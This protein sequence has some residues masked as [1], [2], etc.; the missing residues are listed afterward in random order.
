MIKKTIEEYILHGGRERTLLQRRLCLALP[1][2]RIYNYSPFLRDEYYR[3]LPT[4]EVTTVAN[5][6]VPELGEGGGRTLNNQITK[7]DA[8]VHGPSN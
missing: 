6:D 4:F 1:L 3:T 5:Y 2:P 8:L 7:G